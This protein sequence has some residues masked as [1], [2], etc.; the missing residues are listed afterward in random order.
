MSSSFSD[1][2]FPPRHE[3]ERANPPRRVPE[4]AVYF[5]FG[6]LMAIVRAFQGGAIFAT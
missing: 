2:P 5:E 4:C 6:R 3:P 1:K